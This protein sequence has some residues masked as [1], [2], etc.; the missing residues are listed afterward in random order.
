[1]RSS[2]PERSLDLVQPRVEVHPAVLLGLNESSQFSLLR[3][4]HFVAA[5]HL[6]QRVAKWSENLAVRFLS[7]F[8]LVGE[9]RERQSGFGELLTN[10]LQLL[11]QRADTNFVGCQSCRQKLRSNTVCRS[12]FDLGAKASNLRDKVVQRGWPLLLLPPDD[13][14][15]D[16]RRN[17]DQSE[18]SQNSHDSPPY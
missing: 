6:L 8:Q 12:S 2:R 7:H 10:I 17:R 11:S 3:T 13:G 16:D 1:M 5:L 15:Q 14:R 4:Q 9:G 18:M